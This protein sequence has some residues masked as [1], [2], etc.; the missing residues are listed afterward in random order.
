MVQLSVKKLKALHISVALPGDMDRSK[1][2]ERLAEVSNKCGC[3]IAFQPDDVDRFM[4]R[5]IVFDMDSTLIQQEVIDELARVAGVEAE[6]KAITEA[7]MA[8]ELDF[9][10]SLK[11]RVA[12]LKG[13]NSKA[14][15]D[16]VKQ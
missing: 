16:E 13:S 14:L 8:G 9:F 4:R 11:S 5:M 3:D 12:L 10:G 7:A 6:V 2:A 1:V 15:F